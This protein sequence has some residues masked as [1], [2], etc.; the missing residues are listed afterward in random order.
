[1][2]D[3]HHKPFFGGEGSAEPQDSGLL[4]FSLTSVAGWVS[5]GPPRARSYQARIQSQETGTSPTFCFR[6]TL[7]NSPAGLQAP[8]RH[9]QRGS[10]PIEI[11]KSIPADFYRQWPSVEQSDKLTTLV[12]QV[13][14]SG[15]QNLART[16]VAGSQSLERVARF[17]FP[18]GSLHSNPLPPPGWEY[19]AHLQRALFTAVE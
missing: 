1:M 2:C 4:L 17:L 13:P 12:G 3:T 14:T 10:T 5:S 11:N 7:P 19:T 15:F 6:S 9:T 18:V 8:P 16:F